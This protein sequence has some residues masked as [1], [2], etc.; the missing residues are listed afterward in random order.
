MSTTRTSDHAEDNVE[1]DEGE[2]DR[3]T[4]GAFVLNLQNEFGQHCLPKTNR[5]ALISS[6]PLGLLPISLRLIA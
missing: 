3:R 5:N 1:C 4:S 2:Q 6:S